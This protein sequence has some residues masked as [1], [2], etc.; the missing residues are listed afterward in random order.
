MAYLDKKE[1]E[2][3]FFLMD[4]TPQQIRILKAG[5]DNIFNG[6]KSR[7]MESNEDYDLLR[8]VEELSRILILK[9]QKNEH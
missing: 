8:S 6:M 1:G 2:E 5:S 9:P 3:T 4:L 7:R